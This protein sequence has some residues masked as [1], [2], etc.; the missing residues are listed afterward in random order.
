MS[1]EDDFDPL[2]DEENV[3]VDEIPEDVRNI[4][5]NSQRF[6]ASWTNKWIDPRI[7]AHYTVP[8][9]FKC[10]S[11]TRYDNDQTD[12]RTW[13]FYKDDAANCRRARAFNP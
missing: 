10:T 11:Y 3:P 1:E 7:I 2:S 4:P 12:H 8:C 9:G 6:Y 13:S 5:H